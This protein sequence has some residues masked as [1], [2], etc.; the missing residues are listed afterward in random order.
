MKYLLRLLAV[1]LLMVMVIPLAAHAQDATTVTAAFLEGEPLTLDPQASSTTSQYAVLYNVCEG[2]VGYDPQTLKP[3]PA[4]A[5]SWTVSAD[6]KVYTFKLRQGVKFS[7]GRDLTADDVIYS[8]N[9]MANPDTGTGYGASEIAGDIVGYKAVH[10]DK[11]AKELS[12]IKATDAS[13]VEITLGSPVA[14]YLNQLTLPG[15]MI[16][17]KE[18]VDSVGEKP[19]CTGPYT[20]SQWDRQS[21]IVLEANPSYWGGAPAV[22]KAVLRIIP[23]QSQQVIEFEAGNVDIAWVPEPDLSRL[24]DDA[25][26]SKELHT[27]PILHV[28]HLRINLK[29]PMM[30]N[31]KV[32]LALAMAID[33]QTIVDTILGGQG[34]P[35]HGLYPPNLSTYDPKFDPFPYDPQ[36]AKQ[37]L[38]DAGY[39]N[40]IDLEVRTGQIET[41]NRVMAAVQQQVAQAGI[42]LK[43]NSTEQSVYD[44][45]RGKCQM[46]MGTIAWGM[47]YPDPD[48]VA[49]L[50]TAASGGS[51]LNCGY[52]KDDPTVAQVTDLYAK[53]EAMPLGQERD[54]VFR[55]IEQLGM[56]QVL[57]IPIYHGTRTALINSRLGGMPIDNDSTIRFALMKLS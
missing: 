39:P 26:L 7:N 10:D 41:E 28:F 38:A 17:A 37:I 8:F 2:L 24:H 18:A 33:R 44:A 1:A 9:R 5:E 23:E 13:T 48:N 51:R 32:R 36:K 49:L 46:Q 56:Q 19:V 54:D 50:I 29:D 35:A 40:G 31:P 57:M 27:I 4:L 55:Q 52:T 21:Q 14:S 3:V 25:T 6:G 15:G 11:T 43:V 34:A 12:G 47:D 20:V 53:A 45:D 16:I 22:Q 30:S 42:R